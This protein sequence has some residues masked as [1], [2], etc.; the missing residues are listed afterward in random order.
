[1]FPMIQWPKDEWEFHLQEAKTF[2]HIFQSLKKKSGILD[3][4]VKALIISNFFERSD[5]IEDHGVCLHT[6]PTWNIC[7]K[8]NPSPSIGNKY[9]NSRQAQKSWERRVHYCYYTCTA[10]HSSQ[11][12][13]GLCLTKHTLML[14]VTFCIIEHWRKHK[15]LRNLSN[16]NLT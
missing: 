4:E 5:S 11:G 3:F 2:S 15:C 14:G 6:H 13:I 8:L 10:L 12:F 1:M 16:H 7:I 9:T